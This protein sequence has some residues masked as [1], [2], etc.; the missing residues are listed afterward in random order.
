MVSYKVSHVFLNLDKLID[1]ATLANRAL[2]VGRL[3]EANV[4][5]QQQQQQRPRNSYTLGARGA[6]FDGQF[7]YIN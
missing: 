1:S 3:V 2:D 4:L 5:E 7:S 6:Q